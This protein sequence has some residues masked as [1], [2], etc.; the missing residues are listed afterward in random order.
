MSPGDQFQE[1]MT[2]DEKAKLYAA[3]GYQEDTTDPTL[4]KEVWYNV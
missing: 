2:D 3:I 4:P 1:L